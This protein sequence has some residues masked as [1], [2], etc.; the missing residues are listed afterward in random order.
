M[1]SLGRGNGQRLA[2]PALGRQNAGVCMMKYAWTDTRC[3]CSIQP[4][5]RHYTRMLSAIVPVRGRGVASLVLWHP[6]APN[7]F[8]CTSPPTSHPLTT[9]AAVR[10]NQNELLCFVYHPVLTEFTSYT[11]ALLLTASILSIRS[12]LLGILVRGY[13]G[14]DKFTIMSL[15]VSTVFHH[16]KYQTILIFRYTVVLSSRVRSQDLP[17]GCASGNRGGLATR[18]RE[19]HYWSREAPARLLLYVSGGVTYKYLC[20][21]PVHCRIPLR[22]GALYTR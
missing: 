21:I 20:S 15:N 7:V 10:T 5:R 17:E 3:C 22:R 16:Y 8:F 13:N 4:F 11:T 9:A 1:R 2:S 18:S 14:V 12:V 19:A 6:V